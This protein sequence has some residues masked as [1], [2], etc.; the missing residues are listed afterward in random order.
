MEVKKVC[1]AIFYSHRYEWRDK[2]FYS[3]KIEQYIKFS[4][5]MYAK[6]I[7]CRVKY[8]YTFIIYRI[9]WIYHEFI[10]LDLTCFRLSLFNWTLTK[11]NDQ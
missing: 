1:I 9:L 7:K 5:N 4:K 8:V 11:L 3:I 2:S 10:S 6:S